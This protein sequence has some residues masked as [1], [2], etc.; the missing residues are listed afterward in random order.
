MIAVEVLQIQQGLS[1]V[2]EVSIFYGF[3]L[4]D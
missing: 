4:A 2:E 1:H 3:G